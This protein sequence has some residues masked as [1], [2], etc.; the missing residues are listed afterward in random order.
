MYKLTFSYEFVCVCVWVC[1]CV[2]SIP[3]NTSGVLPFFPMRWRPRV[4]VAFNRF[5]FV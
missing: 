4:R 2:S 3:Q 1:V 5:H